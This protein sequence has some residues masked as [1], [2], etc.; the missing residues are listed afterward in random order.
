MLAVA[1]D[2]V[3]RWGVGTGGVDDAGRLDGGETEH[4]KGEGGAKCV[5]WRDR[6]VSAVSESCCCTGDMASSEGSPGLGGYVATTE[7]GGI[8]VC[9]EV[10]VG[11]IRPV[12]NCSDGIATVVC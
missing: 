3:S 1:G 5:R 2:G 6:A 11:G 8:L 12:A 7:A 4:V 9:S 10:V